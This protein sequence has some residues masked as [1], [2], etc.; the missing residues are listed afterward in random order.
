[1]R[2]VRILG[3]ALVAVFVMSAVAVASASAALPEL[4]KPK[5]TTELTKKGLKGKKLGANPILENKKSEKVECTEAELKSGEGKG[6]KEVTKVKILFSGCTAS[7]GF[8]ECN[9]KGK[10]GKG[11]I[12]TN[13]LEGEIAYI[14]KS[15]TEVGFLLKPATG[16]T[17]FVTFECGGIAK[18]EVKG[19]VISKIGEVNKEIKTGEHL[20]VKYKKGAGAGEQEVTKLEGK[21]GE[22]FLES[23]LNKGAFEKSNE[24]AEGSVEFEEAAELKA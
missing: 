16:Q 3:L 20:T 13:E 22:F 10:N 2:R 19:S 24:Q 21:T 8:V 18:Q 5:S 6:T 7:F 9:N 14:N 12:E 23:K 11:E 1:M 4:T 15:K 17:V